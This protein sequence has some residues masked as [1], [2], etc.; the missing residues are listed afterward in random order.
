MA[1]FLGEGAQQVGIG[2]D[3]RL[4][5]EVSDFSLPSI[6]RG[7]VFFHLFQLSL[8]GF[9]D[10]GSVLA[11]E[12]TFAAEQLAI[13]LGWTGSGGG[14]LAGGIRGVRR[15]GLDLL[16]VLGHIA[17][18]ETWVMTRTK[19]QHFIDQR[20]Q[21]AAVV[22]DDAKSAGVFCERTLQNLLTLNIQVISRLVHDQE[23][24]RVQ[25][26][27][28]QS[29]ARFF[30]A[31]KDADALKNVITM[32]QEAAQ[33]TAHD[34]ERL[35]RGG[36]FHTFQ[37]GLGG[38]QH[39]RMR[40]REEGDVGVETELYRTGVSFFRHG[41]Q[42]GECRF[43]GAVH[44]DDGDAVAFLHAEIE[45][46][47]QVD[48]SVGL[49]NILQFHHR[50]AAR[51]GRWKVEGHDILIAFF[52]NQFDFFKLLEAALNL[53]GPAGLVAEAVDEGARLF[54]LLLLTLGC[55]FSGFASGGTLLQVIRE[56]SGIFLGAAVVQGNRARHQRIEQ[57]HIVRNDADRPAVA[58]QILFQPA[59]TLQVQVVRGFVEQEYIRL[60][61]KEFR[62]GNA[63]LPTAGELPA[64]A[65]KVLIAKAETA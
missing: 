16:K 1:V 21:E 45:S 58:A 35:A 10:A 9:D 50:R 3:I 30:S 63:H 26:H 39:V 60:P 62:Q 25:Q 41:Y 36:L 37:H 7:D 44:T 33:Q 31:G 19:L 14:K 49:G 22:G 65:C 6:P 4:V 8:K 46:L 51:R 27:A 32:E 43:A 54:D 18:E 13:F 42:A 40:L 15:I 53:A 5:E 47:E 38:I 29:H 34:R 64:V 48:V 28:N 59:L 61:E 55:L 24:G 2:G 20:I 56:V 12:S 57:R 17:I 52:F 11:C 23:V